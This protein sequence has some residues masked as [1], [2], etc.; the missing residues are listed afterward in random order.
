MP[1]RLKAARLAKSLT[2]DE[3]ARSIGVKQRWISKLE[4]G[5]KRPNIETLSKLA[6]LYGV[7]ESDLLQGETSTNKPG[8]EHNGGHAVDHAADHAAD[9]ATDGLAEL[10]ADTILLE[11][12]R[13]TP[14]EWTALRSIALPGPT[15]KG[16]YIQLLAT[17]RGITLR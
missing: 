7:S 2:Q 12:L 8:R 16:G 17:I 5:E 13:I 14:E 4:R 11:A 10:A 6:K 15:D 1:L 9:H 3:V